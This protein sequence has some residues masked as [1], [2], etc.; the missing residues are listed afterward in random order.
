MP[1]CLA[2]CLAVPIPS[3]GYIQPLS[4]CLFCQVRERSCDAER[5]AD[6]GSNA[7]SCVEKHAHVDT[8]SRSQFLVKSM[9]GSQ[10]IKQ[11]SIYVYAAAGLNYPHH[12]QQ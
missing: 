12:Q 2:V 8:V 11:A 3:S 7:T 6:D 1:C 5:T 9:L 4:A 10:A